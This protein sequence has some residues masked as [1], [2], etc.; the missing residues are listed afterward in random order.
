MVKITNNSV[1]GISGVMEFTADTLDEVKT[2]TSAKNCLQGSVAII[3]GDDGIVVYMKN[4][5]GEWIE[6]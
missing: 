3:L 2:N 6:I 5:K 4:G 1:N